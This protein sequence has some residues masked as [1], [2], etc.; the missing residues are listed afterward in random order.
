MN[1]GNNTEDAMLK[2]FA[3]AYLDARSSGYSIGY[4]MGR[5]RLPYIVAAAAV[6]LTLLV[7]RLLDADAMFYVFLA[8]ALTGGVLR[9]LR[10]FL[11]MRASWRAGTV[12]LIDWPLVERLAANKDGAGAQ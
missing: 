4:F 1:A 10:W 11:Y 8:G 7:L 9:D 3:Q 12:K 5:F 2:G 6:L